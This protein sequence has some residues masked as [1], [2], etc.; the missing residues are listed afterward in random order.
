M[1]CDIHMWVEK[2]NPVTH[3]WEDGKSIFR[4]LRSN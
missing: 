3:S 2:K 1:G 4:F